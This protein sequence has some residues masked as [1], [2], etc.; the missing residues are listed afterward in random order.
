M[1]LHDALKFSYQRKA[2]L[3]G[4]PSP[5]ITAS[6]FGIDSMGQV[7]MAWNE[8]PTDVRRF[9][10]DNEDWTPV[11]PKPAM[12]II[13]EAACDWTALETK[14]GESGDDL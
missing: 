9:L 13:A 3:T 6:D 2:V 1:K 4:S 5:P 11:D 12:L 8:I 7:S 10:F 14:D